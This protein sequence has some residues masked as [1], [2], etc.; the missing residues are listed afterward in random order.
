MRSKTLQTCR[1]S[2][3]SGAVAHF[4]RSITPSSSIYNHLRC[5]R[6]QTGAGR[7][8]AGTRQQQSC[9][10]LL[11]SG[12][13]RAWESSEIEQSAA[14]GPVRA[15]NCAGSPP[16]PAPR[17][18]G[19]CQWC[20]IIGWDGTARLQGQVAYKGV[21]S[22]RHQ[23]EIKNAEG[24]DQGTRQGRQKLGRGSAKGEGGQG[25]HCLWRG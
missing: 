1:A 10:R 8:V 4:H 12:C 24:G 2:V 11:L 25:R 17:P 22:V 16:P 19:R 14:M 13:T 6:L 15:G 23:I 3:S 21:R 7:Q 18:A 5:G 20:L 9:A